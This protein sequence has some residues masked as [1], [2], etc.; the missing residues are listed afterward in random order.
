M[1][2]TRNTYFK[3]L[4]D[5]SEIDRRVMFVSAD[6]AGLVFEEYRRTHPESFVNVGIAEQNM[7]AVSCGLALAG[8]RPV[9]YGHA[10][11][12]TVRALDQIRNCAAMMGLPISI[13]V[14][15]IGFAQPY[16]G[17]T[18]YNTDDFSAMSLIPGVRIITPSSPSMGIA[19]ADYALL[20]KHPLYIRFDPN[21]DKEIYTKHNID[22]SKGFQILHQG[23]TVAVVTSAGYTHR[24]LALAEEWRSNGVDATIIDVYS[25]P[26]DTARLLDAVGSQP[27]VVVDEQTTYGSLGARL[28]C[29]LNTYGLRNPVWVL[30]I[31]FGDSYPDMSTIDNSYFQQVYGLTD[32]AIS[33][34]V[35]EAANSVRN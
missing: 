2:V 20:T 27:I 30:G 17:A 7:I 13:V 18:H 14:N 31:D 35:T 11:F 25:V 23:E 8:K 21:C 16:F 5:L 4:Q 12:A 34:A 19:A 24:L 28:L 9:A 3:R 10:P 6:C 22:F 15:G 33:A 32:D 1:N 26:Y 29:D